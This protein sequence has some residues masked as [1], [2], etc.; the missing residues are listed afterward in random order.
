MHPKANPS[1]T[2]TACLIWKAGLLEPIFKRSPVPSRPPSPA[3]TSQMGVSIYIIPIP[4]PKPPPI[5]PN[6]EQAYPAS[7]LV[8]FT[9][10]Y[11]SPPHQNHPLHP[12]PP[13]RH[14]RHLEHPTRPSIPY[15]RH[16]RHPY[17]H[18]TKFWVVGSCWCGQ[19]SLSGYIQYLI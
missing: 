1:R 3:K 14:P 4:H 19:I 8:V 9:Y 10:V 13:I 17:K 15:P 12:R 16:P 7:I 5:A 2:G 18:V 6:S 11:I